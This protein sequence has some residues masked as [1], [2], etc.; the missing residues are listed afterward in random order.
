V[1]EAA[2]LGLLDAVLALADKEYPN[3]AKTVSEL[4]PASVTQ[5]W[6]IGPPIG[7]V[8]FRKLAG[9]Q[10]RALQDGLLEA[11]AT[12]EDL[13]QFVKFRLDQNLNAIVNVGGLEHTMFALSR[14]T[15]SRGITEAI[16]K[17]CEVKR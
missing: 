3:T 10:W 14:W 2:K 4:A 16:E 15:Q 12:P 9:P 11:F 1:E 13:R 6:R 5:P 8:D 17:V 7:T